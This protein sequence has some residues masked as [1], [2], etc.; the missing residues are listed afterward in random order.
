LTSA[1]YVGVQEIADELGV[2]IQTIRRWILAGKLP[3]TKPGL[4]YLVA[5]EDLDAFLAARS[6]DPKDEAP[7]LTDEERRDDDLSPLFSFVERYASRWQS[8]IDAGDLDLGSVDE[9]IRTASDLMPILHRLNEEERRRLPQQPYSFGVP[10]AKSGVAI[11]RMAK[12]VDPLAA[13]MGEK[14]KSSEFG[15]RL[16]HRIAE[17]AAMHGESTPERKTS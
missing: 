1:K 8:R 3:A 5:R 16:M 15:Q 6:T 17:Q 7:S 13:A 11:M 14:F 10:A 4:K 12:L 2:D 9:F